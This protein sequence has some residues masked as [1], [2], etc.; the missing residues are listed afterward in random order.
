MK[1]LF[2]LC[3]LLFSNFALADDTG[4]TNPSTEWEKFFVSEESA[5]GWAE[6]ASLQARHP[7]YLGS[8]NAATVVR[9]SF[10]T[11]RYRYIAASTCPVDDDRLRFE[12][13]TYSV[14]EE[15]EGLSNCTSY[16]SSLPPS[17]DPCL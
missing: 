14:C 13:V 2:V 8:F 4:S 12:Q 10:V 15:S 1:T 6:F 5:E 3:L 9:A 7:Q 11:S 17:G 16:A